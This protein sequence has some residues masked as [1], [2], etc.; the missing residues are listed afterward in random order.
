MILYIEITCIVN[1][2]RVFPI[3]YTQ[4]VQLVKLDPKSVN[5]LDILR[6]RICKYFFTLELTNKIHNRRNVVI[7]RKAYILQHNGNLPKEPFC[8]KILRQ[9]KG[10]PSPFFFDYEMNIEEEESIIGIVLNYY[11]HIF[12]SDEV[13]SSNKYINK[14]LRMVIDGESSSTDRFKPIVIVHSI[15]KEQEASK[16]TTGRSRSSF[17]ANSILRSSRK[18]TSIP[19]T[20]MF[21]SRKSMSFN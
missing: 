17:K 5:E 11:Y 3:S 2:F 19:N 13:I 1:I 18:N 8:S 4:F 15:R 6:N 21:N 16:K 9:I 10:Q 20:P 12:C 14:S 7:Q